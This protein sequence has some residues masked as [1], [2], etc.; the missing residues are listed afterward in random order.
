MK[1]VVDTREKDPWDLGAECVR[2]KLDSGDYSILA[3]EHRVV[4]ERK[5]LD[6]L[7]QSVIHERSRFFD[8]LERLT[9]FE[10]AYVV[11]EGSFRDLLEGDYRSYAHPNS[12]LGSML[13]M[14]VDFRIPVFLCSDRQAACK[15]AHDL[16]TYIGRKE[17]V[18]CHD[19]SS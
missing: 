4:I 5:T 3:M 15:F 6:D 9:H 18:K 12:V 10:Y 17:E 11:V 16:L 8:E 7:V 2:K 19:R 14:I 13:S 1:F